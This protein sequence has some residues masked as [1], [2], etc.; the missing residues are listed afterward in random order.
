MRLKAVEIIGFKSFVD[1]TVFSFEDAICGIVGPN[2]CG[3]SNVVDAIKWAMGEQSAK[4]MR[5]RAMEDVIFAGSEARR[6]IGMAQVSLT[7]GNED[8]RAPAPYS[9]YAEIQITRRLYRSGESE[10]LINKT[11][12]RLKDVVELFMDTGVGKRAYSI[13]EQGQIG[14]IINSKPEERRVLIEEAAGITKYKSRKDEALRKVV[15][16]QQD[17]VRVSD[18]IA[19]I[20]R[21]LNSLN[22]A[23]KK[24]ERYKR[25]K[26]ELRAI[27]LVLGALDYRAYRTR[28]GEVETEL[29]GLREEAE[30][31]AGELSAGEADRERLQLDAL[32]Y[33][34]EVGVRQEELHR[35]DARV[36]ELE[37]RL[38]LLARDVE[39]LRLRREQ[40]AAEIAA[41]E[42]ALAVSGRE[43]DEGRAGLA[44]F[45]ERLAREEADV[46]EKAAALAGVR[47]RHD[48]LAGSIEGEKGAL[49]D[50]LT[51]IAGTRQALDSL[52][53]RREEIGYRISR[54]VE[55]SASLAARIETLD[56]DREGMAA[57]TAEVERERLALEEQRDERR[58]KAEELREENRAKKR[59]YD[60]TRD[61]LAARRAR[62]G[63]LR[64]MVHN[65]E[66]FGKGVRNVLRPEQERP[67][68]DG[69]RG[70]LADYLR[71]DPRYE[72]ALEAVLGERLQTVVVEGPEHG[73]LAI[74]YL[75]E[76]SEG[77][78]GFLPLAAAH[79][80]TPASA[81]F[82]GTALAAAIAPMS[83]LVACPEPVAPVVRNL[84]ADV[85]V[86]DT[87]DAAI[88]IHKANGYRGALVTL[89]GEVLESGGFMSGG[90]PESLQSG[91]LQKRREVRELE[92]EVERLT[93]ENA[94]S[95][96]AFL[97]GEGLLVA[98]EKRLLSL[99]EEIRRAE[100]ALLNRRTAIERTDDEIARCRA[101]V[102]RLAAEEAACRA[103]EESRAKAAEDGNARIARLDEARARLAESVAA[104]EARAKDLSQEREDLTRLV[105]E[106]RIGIAGYREKCGGLRQAIAQ[107][108]RSVEQTQA[109]IA[110]RREAIERCG[111][112]LEKLA[113][114]DAEVRGEIAAKVADRAEKADALT[115]V[116]DAHEGIRAQVRDVE[117]AVREA[118]ARLD[119]LREGEHRADLTL[120]EL[121]M[122]QDHLTQEVRERY[123]IE[124]A[125]RFEE[126][127]QGVLPREEIPVV[128]GGEAEGDDAEGAVAEAAE[129]PAL[130]P[131][132][133]PRS[134]GFDPITLKERQAFLRGKIEA[135]GE[136]NPGAIEEFH[137]QKERF[138]F[139]T[140]QRADLDE[141]I[142]KLKQAIA[143]INQASR[144]RFEE[145][146][147]AVNAKFTEVVPLL[148]Q[149]GSGELRLVGE[150]DVLELGLDIVIRPAGKRLQS[151]SLLSGGE[152]ALAAI[153]LIFSIFLHKPSPFALLDEVDAPLDDQNILRFTR[154]VEEMSRQT[155]FLIITHNKHSM[156][157]AGT[158]YGVT[159]E[160]PGVSKLVAV[161]F[162]D[163]ALAASA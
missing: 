122:K 30:R 4:Q 89:D 153:A 68:V 113:A 16:T 62:L 10:Y 124:L 37:S 65:L 72:T 47:E 90:S 115:A 155:Q 28:L 45:E 12:V 136:V 26:E 71:V 143:R 14:R 49:I 82:P 150:G 63:G 119:T 79:A 70:V 147:A 48:A 135:M 35:L 133:D 50:V 162:E 31:A 148:F 102:V 44:D 38:A 134:E 146:F 100:V 88:D 145:T 78:G 67:A 17:L 139:Y 8:G 141:A 54:A 39:N 156:E 120:Q 23:A 84:L 15:S 92:Q 40:H 42:E 33:E 60:E 126:F 13:I 98:V 57:A 103:E 138:E 85:L 107:M 83:E 36:Q 61:L 81:I 86:V 105:T 11:P 93:A 56:A 58:R 129:T 106:A 140:R 154:L 66:G 121:R 41:H 25:Y 99:D 131:S 18:T 52:A 125:E 87:L 159:M 127:L 108:E 158:L 7:F 75:K 163:A 77:R 151:M 149:G 24:A 21:N 132:I 64:E 144:R 9:Q 32:A 69:V 1:R 117:R 43:I 29:A 74:E 137:A 55:E 111:E 161:R 34:K 96:D 104:A 73:L 116:R 59:R 130:P 5:G 110:M 95:E 51:E 94:D 118:R 128:E 160:E 76:R 22:R 53:G 142:D 19:E 20:K 3:K 114:E 46:A 97:K 6:P 109:L 123:A 112:D 157:I 27:D 91:I 2:G 152:K 101:D 80:E